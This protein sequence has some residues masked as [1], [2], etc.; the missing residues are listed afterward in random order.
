MPQSIIWKSVFAGALA[1]P[2]FGATLV[3]APNDLTV[4]EWG[5]FTSVAGYD[6]SSLE[7]APLAFSGDLP[8]FV[9][10]SNG[11]FAKY[12]PGL[13]RMET[14]VVYF[15]TQQPV[16]A[17][18]R[19]DFPQGKMTEWYPQAQVAPNSGL[20]NGSIEWSGLKIM[21][22]AT[23]DLPSTSGQSRYYPARSTDSAPV[24]AGNES[25]KLLFYRG[26]A[27]FRAPIEPVVTGN[28]YTLRNNSGTPI[29]VAILFENRDGKI[30]YRVIHN[31]KDSAQVDAPPLTSS[32]DAIRRD[33]T[34]ILTQS[35]LYP[36][37]AAAML[38]TWHDSWFEGGTRVI[39]IDPRSTVDATLPLRVS[40]A[41][42]STERVF[43]GRVEVLSPWTENAI[44][45]A[46]EAG[47]ATAIKQLGRFLPAFI[48]EMSRHGKLSRTTPGSAIAARI[49][50][51][52]Y[53]GTAPCI[54]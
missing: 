34:A 41:P 9:H 19:V 7:W 43:V 35:G 28:G 37:E 1:I 23:P 40:P 14:P 11:P 42:Q 51:A 3:H 24:Q 27:N 50:S 44:R 36:K 8:C 53:N 54:R 47:D 48:Y 21:P 20:K 26:V 31:L 49:D 18:V 33:M 17:S 38:E 4:H 39:Y 13:V 29:P 5:T 25:E 30:G 22:G 15:Y 12:T 32:V 45:T 16:T 2:L 6:G 10:T 52:N 46:M